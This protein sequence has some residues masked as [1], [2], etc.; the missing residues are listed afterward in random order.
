MSPSFN[1]MVSLLTPEERKYSHKQ[2]LITLEAEILQHFGFDVNFQTPIPALERFLRILNYDQHDV[3]SKMSFQILR[4]SLVDGKFMQF[5]PSKMAAC[6]LLLSINIFEK[7]REHK[8]SGN[9]FKTCFTDEDGIRQLNT[10]IWDN[11]T[12]VQMTGYSL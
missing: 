1:R 8:T 6:A 5:E 2:D 10:N 11:P 4:A 12:T 3:I 9:F 7:N